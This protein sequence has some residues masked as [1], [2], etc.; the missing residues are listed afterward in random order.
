[1]VP[2]TV[3]KDGQQR[4][5]RLDLV[6]LADASKQQAEALRAAARGGSNQQL[7]WENLA[8]EIESLG[9]SQR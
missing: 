6:H 5:P 2:E 4:V 9:K 1:L 3:G 8:E 7:D